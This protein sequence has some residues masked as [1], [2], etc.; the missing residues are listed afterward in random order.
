MTTLHIIFWFLSGFFT[1]ILILFFV[2]L[3]YS[4]NKTEEN[5]RDKVD[6]LSKENQNKQG[7]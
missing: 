4:V 2:S 1:C 6:R 5:L 7:L 3:F